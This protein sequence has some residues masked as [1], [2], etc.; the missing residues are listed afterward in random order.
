[1]NSDYSNKVAKL[2]NDARPDLRT[3]HKLEFR[4]CFGAVAGYVDG[5]I[6]ISC[7][8]F[9]VAL[10]LPRETLAKLFQDK[11]VLHLKYFP[12]GH[13]KKEYAVIPKRI[14]DDRGRFEE[15]LDRSIQYALSSQTLASSN[16]SD[17]SRDS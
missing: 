14:L 17:A 5:H 3:V 15:L 13:I 16:I 11:D 8:K 12:K 4:N 2:L 9:G 10:R 1:V 7:G 6:F